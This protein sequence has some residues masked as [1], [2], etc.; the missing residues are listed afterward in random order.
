LPWFVSNACLNRDDLLLSHTMRNKPPP[1]RCNTLLAGSSPV[2]V[3]LIVLAL[4]EMV[5][6]PI[7]LVVLVAAG[8]VCAHC[9]KIALHTYRQ[10][11]PAR[12]VVFHRKARPAPGATKPPGNYLALLEV[13]QRCLWPV[14][15][16]LCVAAP[17]IFPGVAASRRDHHARTRLKDRPIMTAA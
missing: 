12:M 13:A 10:H 8:A 5:L 4:P 16:T 15:C 3:G 1:N 9:L 14:R 17:E 6:V 7:R 2:V 11:E